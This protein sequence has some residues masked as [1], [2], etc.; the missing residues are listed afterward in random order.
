[1]ALLLFGFSFLQQF[2][3]FCNG[4]ES[5]NNYPW[6]L[7]P[8][9]HTPRATFDPKQLQPIIPQHNQLTS[10]PIKYLQDFA[11]TPSWSQAREDHAIYHRFFSDKIF[12]ENGFFLEIGGLD[13]VT[14]SNTFLF[15]QALGWKG[16]CALVLSV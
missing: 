16:S 2:F 3:F 10:A 13:G 1:M 9:C 7:K 15:E 5:D 6:V 14:F 12:I 4:A 8:E 11:S